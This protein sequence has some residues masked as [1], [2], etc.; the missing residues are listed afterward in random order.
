[1]KFYAELM[2]G[3]AEEGWPVSID[4]LPNVQEYARWKLSQ[5]VLM[6]AVY[7]RRAK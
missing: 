3:Q 7:G 5:N 6:T 4:E 2:L 1:M